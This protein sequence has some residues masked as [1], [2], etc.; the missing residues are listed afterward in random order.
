MCSGNIRNKIYNSDFYNNLL[1][2]KEWDEAE[3]G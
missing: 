3:N 1:V 2:K